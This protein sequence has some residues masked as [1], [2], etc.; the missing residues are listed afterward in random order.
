MSKCKCCGEEIGSVAI[1]PVCGA[2]HVVAPPQPT[3]AQPQPT[4]QYT[5]AQPQPA[6]QQTAPTPPQS[7]RPRIQ[8]DLYAQRSNA[9]STP[10]HNNS[11]A[12]NNNHTEPDHVCGS[13]CESYCVNEA[14]AHVFD[15]ANWKEKWKQ[16]RFSNEEVG[17]IL[18][19]TRKLKDKS[20]FM[21]T[22]SKYVAYRKKDDVH[23]CLLDLATQKVDNI[24]VDVEDIVD[25]TGIINMSAVAPYYLL[26]VGDNSVI[27]SI[28]W[29][30]ETGDGDETILSDL[31]YISHELESPWEED[32]NDFEDI[33]VT[34]RIPTRAEN[35]FIE[36]IKYFNNTLGYKPYAK[37]KTFAYSAKQWIVTSKQ[38][39][40]HLSPFMITSPEYTSDRNTA[41]RQNL[42]LIRGI[43]DS[44]N[45]LCFN[46]HGSD[47]SHN[48]YGQLG[49]SYPIALDGGVI[50]YQR[51]TPFAVCTEACYGARPIINP[52]GKE[53]I[54]V[55]TLTN[56]ALSFVGS[57]RIAYGCVNGGMS[58]ADVIAYN[59]TKNVAVGETFGESFL[60]ALNAVYNDGDMDEEEI[61]TL[62]EF[63]L[64]GDPSLRLVTAGKKSARP[65]KN[66]APGQK[67]TKKKGSFGFSLMSCDN[68]GF[69]GRANKSAVS[70]LS[71]M[72]KLQIK[73][74]AANLR[75]MGK[76]ALKSANAP[77]SETDP[78]VFKVVGGDGY[79]A[80]Y[81]KIENDVKTVVKLH[82]DENGTVEKMYESK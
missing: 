38:E 77:L 26:I 58:C 37:P 59:Y 22:L 71:E 52:N 74:I 4:P 19:D 54:V 79:R 16:F 73:K 5:Y 50:T 11:N 76:N 69:V 18:T 68:F 33:C 41:Q 72:E 8:N 6:P 80:I 17:I 82:M 48:W 55:H 36:A 3:Y 56:G 66:K 62:A 61:K 60:R 43:D 46:L 39:F 34:G 81:S 21:Q 78:H 40:A 65:R 51:K 31:P 75:L 13:E 30:N 28:E 49:N 10:T 23:Y 70:G 27:P 1:C 67:T 47:T 14:W 24:S 35:G 7:N 44:C 29:D 45:L 57:S 2:A 42:K 32:P 53:S 9:Q 63:A 12:G 25:L 64:Y 20:T 15:N